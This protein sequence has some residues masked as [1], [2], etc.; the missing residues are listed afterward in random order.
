MLTFTVPIESRT[1][2]RDQS[3]PTLYC[4]ADDTEMPG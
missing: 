1:R 2:H 3:M 4:Y